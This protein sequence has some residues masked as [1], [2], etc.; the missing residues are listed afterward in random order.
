MKNPIIKSILVAIFWAGILTLPI[1]VSAATAVGNKICP[2]SGDKIE[3]GE[4]GE[5]VKIEYNGK[6]YTVCCKM[7]V[8]DFNKDPEKY[9]KKAEDEVSASKKTGY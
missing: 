4:M 1:S 6:E 5:V 7:C 8:K 9:T 2:V 3:G